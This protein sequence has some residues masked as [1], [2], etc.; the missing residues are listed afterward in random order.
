VSAQEQAL[1]A[2][3]RKFEESLNRISHQ[4]TVATSIA[5][6]NGWLTGAWIGALTVLAGYGIFS[7]MSFRNRT[8]A[9]SLLGASA[10]IAGCGVAA[11]RAENSLVDLRF[12]KAG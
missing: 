6:L 3:V 4:E 8:L 11:V 12:E 1:H 5:S 2:N 7:N 9:Y 10:Q